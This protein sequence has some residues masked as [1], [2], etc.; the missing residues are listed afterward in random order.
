MKKIDE[1]D[2]CGVKHL[3][4]TMFVKRVKCKYVYIGEYI[5]I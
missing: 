3:Y 5:N 4:K 2:R 1:E